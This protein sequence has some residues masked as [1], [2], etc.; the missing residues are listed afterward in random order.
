MLRR[1]LLTLPWLAALPAAA[2]PALAFHTAGA[3]SAFLPYG[4]GVA[5]WLARQ[6]FA[7]RV[8]RS[9][10]SL[11]NLARVEDDANAIGCAFLGS[12]KDALD[13]TPAA[14]GRRHTHLA[15]LFPMYETSFQVAAPKRSGITE[16]AGLAG[17]RVGVGPAGGP[18]DTFFRLAATTAGLDAST[19]GGD[20]AALVEALAKGEIDA[21]WQGAI[22]PIPS[23]L[24]A[25]QR[26]DAA[27]FGLPPALVAAVVQRAPHLSP[28]SIPAGS[29]PGQDTPLASFAAWNVVVANTGMDHQTA[30][31]LTRMV[32]SAPDPARD[33]HPTAAATL[34]ANAPRNR[35]L[36][37]HPGAVRYYE[38]KRIQ[39]D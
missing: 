21:L 24:A 31:D 29:Y 5:A 22:V 9:T 15:A 26:A 1:P 11:Q 13:G 17:K 30:Y 14:G 25:V 4:E 19:V 28:S 2:Q 39:V 12:V 23:L 35:L 37:Y 10:G 38:E 18:A 27:V 6:R 16:F 7:V 36:P 8:E 3:G 32:L 20:P 33:I 34:A